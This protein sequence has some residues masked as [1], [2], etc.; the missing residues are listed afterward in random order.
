MQKIFSQTTPLKDQN[1]NNFPEWEEKK[2]RWNF[3][4]KLWGNHRFKII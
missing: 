2:A 3:F 4:N 1:G